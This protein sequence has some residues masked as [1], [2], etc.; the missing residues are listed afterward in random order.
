[1]VP[2]LAT[3]YFERIFAQQYPRRL[4]LNSL[5]S[6]RIPQIP[7][8]SKQEANL[9]GRLPKSLCL[10]GDALMTEMLSKL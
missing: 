9:D 2:Q 3:L 10:M 5:V 8:M 1:M 7:A 6:L 4:P